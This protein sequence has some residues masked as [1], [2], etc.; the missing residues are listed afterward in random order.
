M[1]IPQ[2]HSVLTSHFA[3][4][5]EVVYG[6]SEQTKKMQAVST[7]CGRGREKEKKQ[8][9]PTVHKSEVK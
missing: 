9:T 2:E 4:T 6:R 7:L 5:I 1:E 3:K 8:E